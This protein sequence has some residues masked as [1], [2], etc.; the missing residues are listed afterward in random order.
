MNFLPFIISLFLA[1]GSLAQSPRTRPK[2]DTR[3]V[4]KYK[5]EYSVLL[6][7]DTTKHGPYRRIGQRAHNRGQVLE[8]GNYAHGLREG[9]WKLWQAEGVYKNGEKVGV[10]A[11]YSHPDTLEQRY[12]HTHQRL[13]YHRYSSRDYPCFLPGTSDRPDS[14]AILIGGNFEMAR[15]TFEQV[16]YPSEAIRDQVQGKVTIAIRVDEQGNIVPGSY[17]SRQR[18]GGGCDE[19]ALRMIKL[20]PH[21]GAFVPAKKGGQNVAVEVLLHYE[22]RLQNSPKRPLD[23]FKKE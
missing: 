8:Q 6:S 13:L 20:L 12:D 9:P 11:Y 7:D 16:R 14:L 21:Q 4:P 22:F 19:E 17:A 23:L 1:F 3:H 2:A 15:R 5:E 10:W 18:I